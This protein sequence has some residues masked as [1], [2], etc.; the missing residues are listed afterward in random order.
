MVVY[1]TSNFNYPSTWDGEVP[2]NLHVV[3]LTRYNRITGNYIVLDPWNGRKIIL[4]QKFE[5]IYNLMRYAV[6]VQS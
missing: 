6:V 2:L 3:L 1:T 5:S 4:K